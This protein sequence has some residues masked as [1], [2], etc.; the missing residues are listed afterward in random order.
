M[1]F[2]GTDSHSVLLLVE[3]SVSLHVMHCLEFVSEDTVLPVHFLQV[4]HLDKPGEWD[5]REI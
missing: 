5:I 1:K 4:Q 2:L 3:N